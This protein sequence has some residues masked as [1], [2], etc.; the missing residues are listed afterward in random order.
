MAAPSEDRPPRPGRDAA[1]DAAAQAAAHKAAA[2][3]PQDLAT[4]KRRLVF[5]AWHRGIKEADLILGQFV[6][7]HID[8]WDADDV[9]WMERL[10]EEN[11]QDILTWITA[12]DPAIPEPFDT[13]LMAALRALDYMRPRA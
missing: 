8:S 3:T 10:F 4:R 6:E 9:R 11:D 1:L 2:E 7:R 5:R 12:P 13:P